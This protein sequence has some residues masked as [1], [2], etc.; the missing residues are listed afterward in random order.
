[1]YP[2][3]A[4]HLKKRIGVQELYKRTEKDNSDAGRDTQF[5]GKLI[6]ELCMIALT[7][8]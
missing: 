5:W 6:A 3:T 1:M 2:L 4:F 7:M 8:M